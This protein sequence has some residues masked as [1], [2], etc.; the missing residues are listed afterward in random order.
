M[1]R[2]EGRIIYTYSNAWKIENRIYSIGDFKLPRAVA[3][4]TMGFAFI[5]IVLALILS[6]VPVV[7]MLPGS[8]LYGGCIVGFPI[9]MKKARIH[10]KTPVRFAA[11]WVSYIFQPKS[12]TRF[13][14]VKPVRPVRFTNV[15]FKR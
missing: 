10:S 5:G 2:Q 7:N 13:Q 6:R 3:Y 14:P 1:D 9:L 12:M 8:L 4:D 11:G 15:R